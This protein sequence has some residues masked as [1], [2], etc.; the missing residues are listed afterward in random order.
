MKEKKRLTI[1]LLHGWGQKKEVWSNIQNMFSKDYNVI[2]FNLPGFGDEPKP[3]SNYGIPQ[4][5]EWLQNK[6]E[7]MN[8]ENVILLGYSFGGRISA[9]TASKRPQWLKAIILAATP[10]LYRPSFKI[11]IKILIYKILRKF[12]PYKLLYR[13]LSKED[14]DARQNEMKDVR[15]RTITFD[16]TLYL[17][18]ISVPT[19]ILNGEN[20]D[21]VSI[22]MGKETKSL[23]ENSTLEIIPKA[24]H[25]IFEEKPILFYGK[26]KNF[27][28]NL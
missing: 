7:A 12:L 14:Q 13:F 6:I 23:I 19:L 27:I 15:Y 25:F 2:S 22:T 8:L 5:S 18:K 1:I 16:Q 28:E 26:V 9:Y 10:T 4:Y 17:K 20:D 24:S 21:Q 11:K 3:E